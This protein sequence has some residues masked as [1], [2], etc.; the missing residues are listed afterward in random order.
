MTTT[1]DTLAPLHADL[2]EILDPEVALAFVHAVAG[3]AVIHPHPA[4]SDLRRI[5][6]GVMNPRPT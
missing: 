5:A 6:S 1:I 2:L 3:L 4:L